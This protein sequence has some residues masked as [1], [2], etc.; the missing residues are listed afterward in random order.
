MRGPGVLALYFRL[1]APCWAW[2]SN[3][4]PAC[5]GLA[6][7]WLIRGARSAGVIPGNWACPP[8]S[9]PRAVEGDA[10]DDGGDDRCDTRSHVVS[11]LVKEV[12]LMPGT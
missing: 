12:W 2:L 11:E 7:T 8:R 6:V 9:S 10:S 3:D 5:R 1:P 4:V